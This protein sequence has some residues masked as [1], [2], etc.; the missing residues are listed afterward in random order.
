MSRT[1]L[2]PQPNAPDDPNDRRSYCKR[3]TCH[4]KDI[5]PSKT[6]PDCTHSQNDIRHH[7]KPH[8]AKLTDTRKA[9]PAKS[10]NQPHTA[11]ANENVVDKIIHHIRKGPNIEY[12]VRWYEYG[13][14]EDTVEPANHIPRHFIT[15]CWQKLQSSNPT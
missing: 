11:D 10:S 2:P 4:S 6:H 15:R 12:V 14:T 8:K 5:K 9:K 13:P 3:N 1:V 7:E